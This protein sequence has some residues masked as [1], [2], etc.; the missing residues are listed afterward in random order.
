[1]CLLCLV[2]LWNNSFFY[3]D[4]SRLSYR[5][6][7]KE[8]TVTSLTTEEMMTDKTPTISQLSVANLTLVDNSC[9][10]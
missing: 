1:M 7:K 6:E 9:D 8:V 4:F 10:E 2:L 3:P 5:Y